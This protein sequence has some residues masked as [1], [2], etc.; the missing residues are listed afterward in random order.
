MGIKSES[1]LKAAQLDVFT[2]TMGKITA[3]NAKEAVDRAE[4]YHSALQVSSAL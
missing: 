4:S 3:C 1:Q 2:F